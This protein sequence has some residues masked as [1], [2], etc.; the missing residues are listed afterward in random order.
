MPT[1]IYWAVPLAVIAGLL[2]YLLGNRAPQMVAQQSPTSVQGVVVGGVDV[3]KQVAD[4]LGNLR[5]SLQG[6]TDVG[7]ARAAISKLQETA[8]QIDK[9]NGTLGHLSVDQRKLVSG[10]VASAMVTID[11][12]FDK[13][14]AIPGAG[15]VVKPTINALKFKLAELAGQSST[16][17]SSR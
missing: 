13:V 7:S 15:E 9:V 2:W 8:T 17:G 12:L 10:L 5:T 11:Q 1:W 16:I 14:L 4:S 3:G 6:I